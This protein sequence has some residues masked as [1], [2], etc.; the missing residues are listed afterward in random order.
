[1]ATRLPLVLWPAVAAAGL[2]AIVGWV[3]AGAAAGAGAW[4]PAVGTAASPRSQPS[5][6]LPA[7]P[8]LAIVDVWPP[9]VMVWRETARGLGVNGAV[10]SQ[11]FRLEYAGPCHLRLTMVDRSVEQ[12]GISIG[13]RI[14]GSWS[15]LDGQIVR[16]HE[17]WRTPPDSIRSIEPGDCW[18]PDYYL[19][20]PIASPPLRTLASRPGWHSTTLPGGLAMLSHDAAFPASDRVVHEHLEITYGSSEWLPRLV[21]STVDG[22]ET[23]RREVLEHQFG[24]P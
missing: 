10:G 19:L 18:P 20:V 23:Q 24:A 8:S 4:E 13:P 1:M 2:V 6:S 16:T 5:P 21:V 22:V 17:P 14:V 11:T 15:E 7:S 9:L 12:Q 3:G